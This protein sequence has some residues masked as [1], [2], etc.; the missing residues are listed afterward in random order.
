MKRGKRYKKTKEM[1][2]SKKLYTLDEALELIKNIPHAKF[3]ETVDLNLR[4]STG[5][6]K[7]TFKTTVLLPHQFGTT[8]KILV[9]AKGEKVKE[10]QEAG[11][12]FVGAE[13]LAQKIT[14]G[15]FDFDVVLATQETMPI[16]TK[17][18]RILG[19]KGLMPNPKNETVTSD[20]SRVIKEVK[21]GRKEIKMDEAGVIQ[22]SV[23]KCSHLFEQL[24]ENCR[25][26]LDAIIKFKPV[27]EFKKVLLTTTMGP[28][29]K[30]DPKSIV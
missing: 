18:G 29:I 30:I 13:D 19:P 22:V 9:F 7:E 3:D 14:G 15:W 6:Q 27:T 4:L 20:L 1:V 10:A 26:V 21:G 2:D 11:A 5:K 25:I 28:K 23:G 16:V 17:L 24:Q 8:S 12:D